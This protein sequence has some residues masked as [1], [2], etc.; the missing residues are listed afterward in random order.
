VATIQ[1]YRQD[2]HQL[3]SLAEAELASLWGQ[4]DGPASARQLLGD[5]LPDFVDLYGAAAGALAAE[6]YEEARIEAE[7]TGRFEALVAELPDLGRVEALAG[8]AASTATDVQASLSLAQGGMQRIIADVGRQTVAGSSIADR[9]AQ[10][11]QRS[12]AG[13]CG[14]CQ[15]IAGRG[16]VFTSSS[17]VFGSHDHCRC[18][19]VPAWGGRPLPV[20]SY[21]PSERNITDADR[22]R[23]I[24]WMRQNGYL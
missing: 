19:A 14:F 8:W 21:R 5:T 6:W 2:L 24:D 15:M 23:T 18:V 17:V 10:G 9:A 20:D 1:Q 12:A 22:A 16:A 4:V 3:T 7:I 11:W 13:G